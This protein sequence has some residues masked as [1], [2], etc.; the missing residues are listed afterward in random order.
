M[1][2]SDLRTYST[3]GFELRIDHGLLEMRTEGRRTSDMR[4]EPERILDTL[5]KS[6]DVQALSFDLR[7][8][9]MAMSDIEMET[10]MRLICRRFADVPIALIGRK[11]QKD[12]LRVAV[13]EAE[14]LGR[15]VREFHSRSAAHNWLNS[16]REKR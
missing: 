16:V 6:H 8:A 10:R 11:D 4:A 9:E 2:K 13:R 12:Q 3:S 7:A 1:G 15:L 14:R 5:F